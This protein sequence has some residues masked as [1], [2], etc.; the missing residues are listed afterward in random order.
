MAHEDYH[1]LTVELLTDISEEQPQ[2]TQLLSELDVYIQVLVVYTSVMSTLLT[3]VAL[4]I[5]QKLH[6]DSDG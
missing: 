3:I 5:L 1:R 6:K 4:L 2:I